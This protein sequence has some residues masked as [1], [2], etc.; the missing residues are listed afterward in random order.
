MFIDVVRGKS[1]VSRRFSSVSIV[2]KVIEVWRLLEVSM[3]FFI[4]RCFVKASRW[5]VAR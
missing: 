1:A 4:L 5:V 2:W 3:H